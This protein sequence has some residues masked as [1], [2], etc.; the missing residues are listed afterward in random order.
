M[1]GF[2][3]DTLA[4]ALLANG[5]Q[6]VGRSF[7]YHRPRGIYSAG[8]EEPNALV[9]L[10]SGD[11]HEPNTRAT[12]IELF[13]GLEAK[14]QNR[15]PNLLLDYLQINNVLSLFF[16]Q[17]FIT[18]LLWD[19]LDGIFTNISFEKQKRGM[20]DGTKYKDP[21]KYE[22]TYPLRRFSRWRRASWYFR[23]P[24]SAGRAGA[25]VILVD[26]HPR[27]GGQLIG[28]QYLIDGRPALEWVHRCTHDL[29][30]MENVTV[31]TRTTAF[32][33]Y[34][35]NVVNAIENVSDHLPEPIDYQCRQRLWQIRAKRVVLATGATERPIVFSNNDRPGIMLASRKDGDI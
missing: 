11:R 14:S 8:I 33:Y 32:G 30:G 35:S 16:P 34:D 25:R 15:W 5:V 9:A 3:G 27:L 1:I 6:L 23:K 17:A 19:C 7:K 29:D 28:E 10:R 24:V 12:A 31:S 18:K 4:S 2:E 22:K 26:S 13:A 21:D 20:G